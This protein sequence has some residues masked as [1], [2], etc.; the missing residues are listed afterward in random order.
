MRISSI[1]LFGLLALLISP[2]LIVTHL[3]IAA[4]RQ[5]VQV[6]VVSIFGREVFIGQGLTAWSFHLVFIISVF[7]IVFVA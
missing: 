7:P 4:I 1:R 3:S 2:E 6:N 5:L